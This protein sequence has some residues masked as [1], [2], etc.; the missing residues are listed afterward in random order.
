MF[1]TIKKI[2]PTDVDKVLRALCLTLAPPT[3]ELNMDGILEEL[4]RVTGNLLFEFP[5]LFRKGLIWGI[6]LFNW[7]PL[8]FGFGRLRFIS[9]SSEKQ[10]AY[11][12]KWAKSRII[13][14]REFFK[15]LKAMVFVAYFSDKRIWSYLG[16]YPEPHM[17]ERIAFR[18][19]VLQKYEIPRSY[20][21]PF[22]KKI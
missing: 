7:L 8:L 3:K 2:L 9:L 15:T 1:K 5:T 14:I 22:Q 16:Y 17:H 11:V 13:P 4:S 6:R 21:E 18:E 10:K 12:D 20:D 19:T